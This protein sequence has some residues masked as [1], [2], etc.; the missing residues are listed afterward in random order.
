M[1]NTKFGVKKGRSVSTG[2]PGKRGIGFKLTKDNDFD[3]QMKRLTN[4]S[5]PIVNSDAVTK[6]YV[7]IVINEKIFTPEEIIKQHE[8]KIIEND[9]KIQGLRNDFKSLEEFIL[10]FGENMSPNDTTEVPK[11]RRRPTIPLMVQNS[12]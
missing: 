6:E 4:V 12:S 11:S 10:T 9:E 2:P 8:L 1:E 5:Q 7:D 3:I